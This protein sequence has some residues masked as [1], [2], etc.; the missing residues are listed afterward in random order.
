VVSGSVAAYASAK[1]AVKE[2][3]ATALPFD[4]KKYF[5]YYS[6]GLY[7]P[8]RWMTLRNVTVMMSGDSAVAGRTVAKISQIMSC[9]VIFLTLLIFAA[10]A[11]LVCGIKTSV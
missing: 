10:A 8:F 3:E 2:I 6:R 1:A 5:T 7:L 11:I 4:F 9:L